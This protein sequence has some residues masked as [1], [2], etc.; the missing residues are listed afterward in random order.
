M[1]QIG[2]YISLLRHKTILLP[3]S[4]TGWEH[5]LHEICKARYS[6]FLCSTVPDTG[7]PGY[8]GNDLRKVTLMSRKFIFPGM[9]IVFVVAMLIS[10]EF[11][12]LYVPGADVLYL[13]AAI[14]CAVI[15]W[16]VFIHE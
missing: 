3:S 4:E 8:V 10:R 9:T 13:I 14:L 16:F 1:V 15:S 6:P 5:D 2:L 7:L 12:G 11:P